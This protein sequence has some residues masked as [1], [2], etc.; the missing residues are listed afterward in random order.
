M[1]R[2]QRRKDTHDSIRQHQVRRRAGMHASRLFHICIDDGHLQSP[3][4]CNTFRLQGA[5]LRVQNLAENW[6]RCKN[7]EC[8]CLMKGKSAFCTSRQNQ[9]KGKSDSS[10]DEGDAVEIA[11]M[12]VALCV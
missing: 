7:A 12:Q 1:L 9:G 4:L 6:K 5:C 8:V 3:R 11:T 10:T 2:V